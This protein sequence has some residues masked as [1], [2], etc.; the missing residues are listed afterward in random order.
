MRFRESASETA[1][2]LHMETET[3]AFV[4]EGWFHVV[5]RRLSDGDTIPTPIGTIKTRRAD[6]R[7]RKSRGYR[8]DVKIVPATEFRIQLNRINPERPAVLSPP[9]T[10]RNKPS[11][12]GTIPRNGPLFPLQRAHG[13]RS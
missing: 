5:G 10:G 13:A 3:V 4:I 1:K 11:S 2:L 6:A 8:R 7:L 9:K 12:A